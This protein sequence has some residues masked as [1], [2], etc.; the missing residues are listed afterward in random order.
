[1][2]YL[3]GKCKLSKHISLII[4]EYL[5]DRTYVEPFV[6]GAN[7]ID[8]ISGYRIGGDIHPELIALLQEL[9]NGWTPPTEITKEDYYRIK[10]D[11]TSP[12]YLKGF[13]GFS[14][15]FG[16]KWWGG[17]AKN[18]RG[19]NYAESG[20]RVLVKQALNFK[21]IQFVNG[22]YLDLGIPPNSLIYC[23]PPYKGTTGYKNNIDYD[24][25]WDW[26]RTKTKEGHT[27]FISE[28]NAP[29]DFECILEV[30]CKTVLDKNSQKE[31]T[32]KL[33]KLKGK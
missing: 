15:S 3:G 18:K 13:V 30:K 24:I 14:C 33:F 21:D 11:T 19:D 10:N 31:R 22:S 28:Y 32:E 6:G 17:F 7:V 1:M 2:Q 12:L 29:D 23:D 4:M 8:K 25:F 27:V 16:G 26:C 5:G 9:Q 20:S